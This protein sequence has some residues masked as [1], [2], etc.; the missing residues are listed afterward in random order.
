MDTVSTQ[1]TD[2]VT[3]TNVEV[4]AMAPV[5]AMSNAYQTAA[6]A[7]GTMFENAVYIQSQQNIS[8]QAAATKGFKQIYNSETISDIVS[9]AGILNLTKR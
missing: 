5:M 4:T 2:A 9:I 6:H 1:L 8:A 3:Q 7:I